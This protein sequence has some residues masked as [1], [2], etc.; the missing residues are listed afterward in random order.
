YLT[1]A[2][3]HLR[4]SLPDLFR[5]VEYLPLATSGERGEHLVAFARTHGRDAVVTVVPR[6]VATFMRDKDFALPTADEWEGTRV[7]GGDGLL[8]GRWCNVLTGEELSME[9]D[10]GM[11]ARELFAAF[12]VALLQRLT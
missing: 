11:E 9:G 6:L 7:E 1:R 8:A 4:E 5:D 2:A 12:P 3:L 10:G